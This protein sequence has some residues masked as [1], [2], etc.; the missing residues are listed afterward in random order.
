MLNFSG[1]VLR[2]IHNNQMGFQDLSNVPID[3]TFTTGEEKEV[4]ME[5]FN[6]TGGIHWRNKRYWGNSSVSHCL[7]FGITCD[8]TSGYIISVNLKRNNL[9]GTLPGSLWKLRNLRALRLQ[10]NSELE[11]HLK[12]ILSENMTTIRYLDLAFNRLSGDFPGEIIAHMKSLI[13]LQLCC[14]TGKGLDGKIPVDIG[15]LEELE[16]LSLGENTL[17][18]PIPRSISRLKKIWFLDLETASYLTSGF[19]YLF[20]LSSLQYMHLSL[21]GLSGTLPNDFGVFFPSLIEC[22]LPGNRFKGS[23]P[24][25]FGYMSNLSH[26][27]LANNQ[28]TGEI[29]KNIGFL[30]KLQ[31]ADFSG[32]DLRSIENETRFQS[33]SLEVLRLA[34]NPKLT[35]E[36]DELLQ[37][38]KAIN[39]SLRI[40]NLSDCN[41][42]GELSEKLWDF[43]NL[44]SLDLHHNK[45]TGQ[46]P[47]PPANMLFLLHVDVSSNYLSG[48]IPQQF[49]KLL[50]LQFLDVSENPLMGSREKQAQTLP[51][52]IKADFA[53][54][55]HRKSS[56][57]FRCP[58]ARLKYNNG[59]VILDPAY[60][61]YVLCICD[62]GFYGVHGVCLP[63]MEGAVCKDQMLPASHLIMNVGYWPSSRDHNVSHLVNC[64]GVLYT[65]SYAETPCNPGGNCDCWIEWTKKANGTKV[66]PSTVCRQSCLCRE[67]SNGRFCSHC[68]GGYYQQGNLCYACPKNRF[69]AY[70]LAA[71]AFVTMVLLTLAFLFYERRRIILIAFSFAQIILLGLLVLLRLIP[72]WLFELNTV[73]LFIGL[74]GKGKAARG[75]LKI[76]I[77]YFQ[78]LD[79]LISNTAI[80]PVEVL[81]TQHY[82][83]NV[84]NFRFSG[85]ACDVPRLF[86]PVGELLSL[87][88]LPVVCILG[89]WLYYL[90]GLAYFRLCNLPGRNS[91]LQNSCLQLTIMTLNLTY[92]PIVKKTAAVLARCGEDNNY[93][94]FRVAP[95]VD[96]EG[97]IYTV[98]QVLGWLA[99]FIYVL[100]V[101]LGVFLPLLV[102]FV[103]KRDQKDPADQE[104]MD[105]WLGSIYL[106][107]KRD[108]HTSFEVLFLFRRMLIAFSLSFIAKVSSL[109][110]IAVCSVLLASLSFQL[111]FRPFRDSYRNFPLENAAETS[112]LW[113]LHFSFMNV[114][115]ADL[116]HASSIAIVWMT[117]AVNLILTLA[118]VFSIILLLGRTPPTGPPPAASDRQAHSSH[119]ENSSFSQ[120]D[121]FHSV[122]SGSQRQGSLEEPSPGSFCP[123]H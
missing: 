52:Y 28:F 14:Q 114:R 34:N 4:L 48:E 91:N 46:L 60:Y 78:S 38:L 42:F 121:P 55:T 108:F 102:K 87:I 66:Q 84:F 6:R 97:H 93:R 77:F 117:V 112:V 21:S 29:P 2:R 98:L 59:L 45:L 22:L 24:L 1:N 103:A 113:I 106:P 76:S 65:G 10:S 27:N 101:P 111:F 35:I 39:H 119:A 19:E 26:L 67:G 122:E 79:A 18:G 53:T 23:I 109:Q 86:T 85:L 96:C 110:T 69:S 43:T 92:F 70:I 63:C 81:E 75:I 9:I 54:L 115:Y 11:G 7:W 3:E 51:N 62:I 120:D 94:Y 116:N 47:L 25:T 80:W 107:Y 71:L 20:N 31:I 33:K 37:A 82:I 61:R 41:V 44:I 74:A 57:N 8:R 64:A 88:V 32:N 118:L 12:E 13:E 36:F 89:I 40:L 16:V 50:A 49:A 95:W 15:N 104:N 100:G 72:G 56:E 5:I 68:E 90:V 105:A 17:H 30:P 73:V 58:N 99:L 83:S 123:P